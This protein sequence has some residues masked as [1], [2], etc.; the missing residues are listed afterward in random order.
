M[1][2]LDTKNLVRDAIAGITVAIVALPLALG[3][4]ITSGMSAAAGLTTAILAGFVAAL[5]GGSRFQVSGPTGAMTVVLVPI[6]HSYGIKAIPLLGLMAG[7]IVIVLALIKAGPFINRIPW[8]VVEGFTVG[9]AAVIALQ[10]IPL[11][12]GIAK[13]AGDRSIPIA[14]GTITDALKSGIQWQTLALV[15]LTIL[16]KFIFP[17]LWKKTHLTFH[18]PASAVAIVVVTLVLHVFS[19]KSST[20]GTIPR[21]IGT[22]SGGLLDF[23]LIQHLLLPAAMIAALCAIE[24][25]LSARVAD[26]MAHVPITEHFNTNKELLGQGVAT[27][28]ASLFGGMPATGAIARTSVNVR[29]HAHSKYASVFHALVLLLVALVA[30]PLVS[31]IPSAAIAGVLIGTSYRI[32]N[33]VSIMESLRTTKADAAVLVVTAL[34]TLAIDLIWGIGIGITL[35]LALNY[36]KRNAKNASI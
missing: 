9:I 7:L 26:S 10:Q 28:V 34:T 32:L 18:I 11:A 27:V 19:I 24:S 22:W 23:G 21:S 30:A 2:L 4:G 17:Q 36:G 20:I 31:A 12:L 35:F 5:L 33:P 6:I 13:H 16:I 3:F 29:A 25:L 8:P 1:K 14:V 15:V